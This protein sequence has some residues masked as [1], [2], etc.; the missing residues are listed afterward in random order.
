MYVYQYCVINM[1]IRYFMLPYDYN[2]KCNI[3]L[4]FHVWFI[5]L[6]LQNRFANYQATLLTHIMDKS[7]VLVSLDTY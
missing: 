5:F 3:F 6:C 1:Y 4:L 7:T 2:I